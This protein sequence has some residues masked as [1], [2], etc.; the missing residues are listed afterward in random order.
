MPDKILKSLDI[1]FQI[2]FKCFNIL[3][4]QINILTIQI[5]LSI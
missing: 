3:T 2:E 5:K 4:I 1:A